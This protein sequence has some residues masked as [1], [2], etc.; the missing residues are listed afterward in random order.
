MV[1]RSFTV[2]FYNFNSMEKI[3]NIQK[4]TM[5]WL[6]LILVKKDCG[7]KPKGFNQIQNILKFPYVKSKLRLLTH[8]FRIPNNTLS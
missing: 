7:L 4:L 1:L 3:L 8:K 5:R 6:T 2:S